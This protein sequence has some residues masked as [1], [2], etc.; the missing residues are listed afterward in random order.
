[1]IKTN[2]IVKKLLKNKNKIIW[3]NDLKKIL[4]DFTS[5]WTIYKKIFW[6]KSRWYLLSVKK[7][8]FYIKDSTN[9]IDVEEVIDNFYRKILKNYIKN[10]YWQKY[11]I[12]WIKALEIRNNNTSVP[13]KLVLI[14]PYK[15]ANEVLLKWKK[16]F[17]TIYNIK[18]FDTENSFKYFKK[19]TTKITIDN[20]NFNIA[21]YELSILESL[22]SVSEIDKRYIIELIKKN[23]RKNYKRINIEIF[24][25]FLK[26]WKYWSSCKLLYEISLWINPIFAE[27]LKNI[28]IKRY[29][30]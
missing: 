5:K 30:I 2:I 21:N 25:Y 12:W 28:L 23:I 15:R 3:I 27:R 17:N 11:F 13:D 10:S 18:W 26:V 14:N 22:Y 4:E 20:K 19:Q 8:L 7:D 6:L 16:I 9:K 24:E 1:M 29:W